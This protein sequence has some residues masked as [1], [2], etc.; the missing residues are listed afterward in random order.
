MMQ[1]HDVQNRPAGRW[2]FDVFAGAGALVS[3][4]PDMLKYLEANLH[5]E[6][7]AAAGAA[8]DSPAA[9]LPAALAA[10]HQLRA[11][12]IGPAKIALA[13]LYNEQT[14]IYFHDGGTGGFASFAAFIPSDD[15]AIVVLYNRGDATTSSP[16]AQRVFFNIVGVM[17]GQPTVKLDQ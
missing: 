11:T 17:S 4:A 12:G 9:T 5:P 10:D 1:G 6:K 7:L 15:R 3:T 13:W 16:L 8:A 2:D 14:K